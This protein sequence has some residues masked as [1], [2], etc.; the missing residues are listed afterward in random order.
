MSRIGKMPIEVAKGVDVTI[1][2]NLVTVK[3]PKGTLEQAYDKAVDVGLSEGRIVVSRRSDQKD[4]R[5]LHG[6]T[7]ALIANMVKGVTEGFEKTLEIVGVGYRAQKAGSKLVLSLGYS[8]PVEME[9]PSGI[10]FEVP[11]VN[12][13]VVK[14]IDKQQVGEWAARVREKR[15]PEVYHGKGVRYAGEYVIHKEGK[16]AKSKK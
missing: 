14:G 5:A 3:G 9:E 11:A 4:H 1:E 13:V 8:H 10:T 2:G 16:A 12:R 6:L 7:R 15:K